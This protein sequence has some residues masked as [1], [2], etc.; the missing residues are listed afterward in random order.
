MEELEK[1]KTYAWCSCGK[2]DTSRGAMEP[3]KEVNLNHI[4]L[5]QRSQNLHQ[6][7]CVKKQRIPHI[8]MARTL[9]RVPAPFT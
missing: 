4:F 6:Y 9:D 5:P 7:V 8:A 3:I 2:S 1:G